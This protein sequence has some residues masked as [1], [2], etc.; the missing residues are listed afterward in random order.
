[1]GMT[2]VKGSSRRGRRP[3]T[4]HE[5]EQARASIVAA[6]ADV[7]AETGS[8]GMS[9]ALILDAAGISRPTFYRYFANAEQPLNV[10]LEES[11]RDLVGGVVGAIDAA[12]DDIAMTVSVIDAYIG[13]ALARGKLLGPL[14]SELY[15][16]SSSPVSLHRA[17]ALDRIRAAVVRRMIELGRAAPNPTALDALVNACEFLVYRAVSLGG[18]TDLT[19]DARS[20]MI[21]I[22][23]VTIGEPDDV[24]MAL[25][26]PGLFG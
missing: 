8:R 10:L 15:D 19:A 26:I 5:A 24:R 25:Q 2:D 21:R 14:F 9:V 12:T 22:A 11:D 1:M 3:Q 16:R 17:E 7:F 20:M 18:T 4:A 23:V 13:W 6:T